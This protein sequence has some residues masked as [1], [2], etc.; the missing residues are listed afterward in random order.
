MF[1]IQRKNRNQVRFL[2]IINAHANA[3]RLKLLKAVIATGKT[4]IAL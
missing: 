2:K 1:F 4:P 3:K